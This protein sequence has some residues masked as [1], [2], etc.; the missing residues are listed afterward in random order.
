MNENTRKKILEKMFDAVW[1]K[2]DIK[3]DEPVTPEEFLRLKIEF[4]DRYTPEEREQYPGGASAF[5]LDLN[6]VCLL[7]GEKIITDALE[8]DLAAIREKISACFR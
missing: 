1:D 5:A 2:T 8:P 3:V 4:Y 6:R 7:Y